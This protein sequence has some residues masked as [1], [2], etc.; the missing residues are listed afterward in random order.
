MWKQLTASLAILLLLSAG[1]YN[2]S[3]QRV[4]A[5]PR[6]PPIELA[7]SGDRSPLKLPIAKPRIVIKKGRRQLLLFS[8][9]KLVRT[10]RIGLGSSPVGDKVRE[11]D[12]RTPEGD[13]YIFTR[14]D[15]S[16]FYLSLGLSYPNMTH[17]RRGLRDALINRAQYETI[18]RALRA[19]KRPP[20]NT[21]LGGDIYIHGNGAQS[22]WTWGC[23]ALENEDML[24]L[25]KA[26]G[27]GTP[28]TIEP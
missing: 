18:V 13:F 23:A 17:A 26:V 1:Q 10:Y 4:S 5:E 2:L 24:E 12:R 27:V 9:D 7:Q 3:P 21:A 25:F 11:G 22:D 16:A 15:K 20:Q 28:V 19:R 14:N 6:S 8:E